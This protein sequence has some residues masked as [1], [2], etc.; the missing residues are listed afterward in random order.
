[1]RIAGDWGFWRRLRPAAATVSG[2]VDDLRAEIVVG[3]LGDIQVGHTLLIG[4][5]ASEEQVYVLGISARTLSVIRGVNGAAPLRHEPGDG[6]SIFE[7]P[8][9]VSEA[10]L[11]HAARLWRG[12]ANPS[13]PTTG[14]G[15]DVREML[16][17]YR[18]LTI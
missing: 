15:S 14:L 3:S 16:A 11:V 18:R 2:A 12:L 4:P 9:P 13:N 8:G 5:T 1:M 10:T 7:Y 17:P 6:I